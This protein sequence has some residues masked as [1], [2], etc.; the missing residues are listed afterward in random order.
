MSDCIFC[1]IVAG[2]APASI[3]YQDDVI[4]TIMTIGPVNPGHVMVIPRKHV[5]YL[6]D[7]DEETGMHLFRIAMRI[8]RAIW[9]SGVQCEGTNMFLADR[10]AAFQEVFHLHLHVF[11]RFRGDS[12]MVGGDWSEKSSRQELDDIADRIRAA[13]QSLF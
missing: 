13:Y 8:E 3:V 5:P 6:A 11:P 1:D 2:K 4:I 12:F 7:M 10:E 9:N